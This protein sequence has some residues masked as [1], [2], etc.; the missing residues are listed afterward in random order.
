MMNIIR[1]RQHSLTTE[2]VNKIPLSANDNKHIIRSNKI[3]LL[4]G[5]GRFR[6]S[7]KTLTQTD[8]ATGR[9]TEDRQRSSRED[10]GL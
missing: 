3:P 5:I 4:T 10:T 7:D 6:L 2:Q 8:N 9:G 1:S